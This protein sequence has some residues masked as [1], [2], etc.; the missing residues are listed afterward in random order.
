MIKKLTLLFFLIYSS[1]AFSQEIAKLKYHG[2]GD[3]YSNPTALPNLVAFCNQNIGTKM[4][5]KI[6]TVTTND[7]DLFNYPIVFMTG[8]GNVFFTEDDVENLRNYLI[9]GGFLHISDN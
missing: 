8:H 5:T 9:S 1:I 2:G 4:S 3:W 6:A 7:I